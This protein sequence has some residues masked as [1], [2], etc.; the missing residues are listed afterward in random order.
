MA[1][2]NIVVVPFDD[3]VDLTTGLSDSV[4]YLLQ[5]RGAPIYLFD[6]DDTD[7]PA[8]DEVANANILGIAEEKIIEW[9][10]G[11]KVWGRCS[12]VGGSSV[13]VSSS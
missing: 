10:S 8:A 7:K 4:P 13:A 5:N 6:S 9:A 2:E 11:G 1:S 3:W 12:S